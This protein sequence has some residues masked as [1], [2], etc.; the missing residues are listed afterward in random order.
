MTRISLKFTV[1]IIGLL[2]G[3]NC[4]QA[5]DQAEND[6]QEISMAKE[7]TE[8]LFELQFEL[9]TFA[10]EHGR[11]SNTMQQKWDQAKDTYLSAADSLTNA[12]PDHL[13]EALKAFNSA[14]ENMHATYQSIRS[15]LE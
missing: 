4:S 7:A 6:H 12:A 9:D 8:Q 14:M 11:L 13:D 1:L 2:L 10:K 15:D 5:P 3:T